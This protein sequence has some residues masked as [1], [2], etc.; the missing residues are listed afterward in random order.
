M[1]TSN[2]AFSSTFLQRSHSTLSLK[3]DLTS[4][5]ANGTSPPCGGGSA[6]ATQS[7]SRSGFELGNEFTWI[8]FR[9]PLVTTKHKPCSVHTQLLHLNIESKPCLRIVQ[10][11]KLWGTNLTQKVAK[12]FCSVGNPRE[13]D[14]GMCLLEMHPKAPRHRKGGHQPLQEAEV[15]NIQGTR[16]FCFICGCCKDM[17]QN[18]QL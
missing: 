18:K 4:D 9:C 5:M 6:M 15:P 11:L 7:H 17:G 2:S 10:G 12:M 8:L 1:Y 13:P 14:P 3:R 16:V